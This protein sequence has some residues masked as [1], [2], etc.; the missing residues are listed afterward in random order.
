MTERAA[1]FMVP[2]NPRARLSQGSRQSKL[3]PE[4]HK[5]RPPA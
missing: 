4:R 3:C 1:F 2:T 5:G